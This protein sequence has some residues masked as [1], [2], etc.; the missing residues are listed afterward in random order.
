MVW[1][2]STEPEFQ[3]KLDWVRDFVKNEVEPL[4]LAFDSHLVYQK[5]HPVHTEVLKPLQQ[6]VKDQGLWACHLGPDLGGLGYGQLKLAL[7]N[8]V[9]GRSNWAPMTF[10]TQA[11]DSG[12]AEI[13]AHYGTPEQKAKYLQPLLDNKIVS[14]FSMTEPQGG[15]DPGVF[16]CRAEKDGDEWVINGEKWFSSNLRYAAFA[17]VMVVTDPTVPIY[18]GASM[19]LVP[20]DTPGINIIRNT[21]LMNE[22]EGEGS[23]AYVRYENVRVPEDH[24]LGGPGQ[25]FVIAQTRLGGGRIHHAMRTIGTCQKA[26]DMMCERALS[27]NTQGS[28][29]AQKQ[30]IQEYVADSWIQLH[31]FRLQVLH[32]AWTIDQVGG[33]KARKEI[34]GVKVA[35]AQVLKDVVY[36]ALHVHGSL[37]VSNEMPLSRMW[38]MLPVMGIADGPTEVH[39]ITIARQ[40]LKGYKPHEGF[41]PSEHL[42]ERV[43]AAK[44]K[45]AEYLQHDMTN[46]L[47]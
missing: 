22:P 6:K 38:M 33:H 12:N 8:E 19:M 45:F 2:F 35:M 40:L 31:Q 17:I 15:S 9:L 11:P 3:E 42:P 29:L 28:V 41:F 30:I 20:T 37:G 44:E 21:G 16:T 46:A 10:G 24:V 34:A 39:K 5:D 7:L 18:Q 26:F 36:K 13:L 25:G 43:A 27:R 1:D 47:L 14:C 4:D 32:A 23:H